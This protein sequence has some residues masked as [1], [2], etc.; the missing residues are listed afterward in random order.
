M[1]L[2]KNWDLPQSISE[3]KNWLVRS[4]VYYRLARGAFW[5]LVGGIIARIFG[6]VTAIFAA[7]MLGKDGYG[8]IG[9]VQSTLGMFGILAGFGLGAT[10]TKYIAQYRQT[11]PEKVGR[12]LGVILLF[13]LIAS[14]IFAASCALTANWIATYTMNRPDLT[15]LLRLGS[16]LLFFS[17]LGGLFSAALSGFEAFR[18]QA[19][20]NTIQGMLA[21]VI[22]VPLIW[23][24]DVYG[25]IGA[26]II[27]AL[28]GAVFLAYYLRKECTNNQVE[29]RIDRKAIEELSVIWR[30][31]IPALMS[32]MLFAPVIWLTNL[33]LVNRPDGFGQLGIFNAA[34]QWRQAIMFLPNLIMTAILPVISETYAKEDKSEFRQAVTLNLRAVWSLALPPTI[35]IIAFGKE[36][37]TLFGKDYQG[38]ELVIKVLIVATFMNVI[39]SVIGILFAGSGR[40]WIG[41]LMNM[42][43]AIILIL[44]ASW[45]VPRYDSLGLA[46]SYVIAYTLHTIW[47]IIYIDRIIAI[48]ILK[49]RWKMF[50]F[51]I[52]L[53]ISIFALKMFKVE[54]LLYTLTILLFSFFPIISFVYQSFI[55][56][57]EAKVNES[58]SYEQ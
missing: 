20:L 18:V 24:F 40:M 41:T 29:V 35:I 15:L 48:G 32:G 4:P 8:E 31:A 50:T 21:V 47:Q 12:I 56:L 3:L 46:W 51:S 39:N 57:K 11:H 10:A 54:S 17:A 53:I 7:R 58:I 38:V 34:N 6:L 52:A 43:W 30:F 23:Y 5:S 19:W 26:F 9:M 1:I 36:L 28:F 42:V 44:M 45:F 2:R 55:L 37:A 13:S 14:G 25:A 16:L 49:E 27:Q 22:V 33:M